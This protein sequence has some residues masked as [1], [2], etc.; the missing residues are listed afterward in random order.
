MFRATIGRCSA[1]LS[2]T[3]S[4]WYID[5]ADPRAVLRSVADMEP[6]PI[7]AQQL[8]RRLHP[9]FSVVSAP[10][11]TLGGCAGPRMGQV[12]IGCYPGLTVVCTPEAARVDP[13]GLAPHLVQAGRGRRT[14]LVS[15]DTSHGWGAFARWERGELRRSFSATR[16]RIGED[17]GLPQIWERPFWAGERPVQWEPG[18]L[19]DPQALPFDPP[20]FA[21]AASGAWLGFRYRG[22]GNSRMPTPWDLPLCGFALCP[23]R[24]PHGRPPSGDR[25]AP[26]RNRSSGTEG[27]AR[28]GLLSW[29]R[30]R[31]PATTTSQ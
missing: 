2:K 9:D 24:E 15:F 19:P 20:D 3:S 1:L 28:R 30:D 12:Y 5:T 31:D 27:R 14:C 13:S 10:I 11:G 25:S 26:A 29:L 6:D 4:L 16:L 22:S 17:K 7:A 21:D 18:E 23:P 8:A